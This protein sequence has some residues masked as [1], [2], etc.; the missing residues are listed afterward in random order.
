MPAKQNDADLIGGVNL[1]N[2]DKQIARILMDMSMTSQVSD[3]M[4]TALEF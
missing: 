3:G 4:V 2:K 1:S